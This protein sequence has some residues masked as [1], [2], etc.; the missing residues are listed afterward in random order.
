MSC[1]LHPS[2]LLQH[3]SFYPQ[4]QGHCQCTS[5]VVQTCAVTVCTGLLQALDILTL[6]DHTY[7][8]PSTH[9]A[10][11]P[12]PARLSS[13]GAQ[14]QYIAVSTACSIVMVVSLNQQSCLQ[15]SQ[16]LRS[17]NGS[18]FK[19][20]DYSPLV[21]QRLRQLFG[22]DNMDYLLSLTGDR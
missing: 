10:S 21:F 13:G 11:L 12:N 17:H 15:V 20:K 4:P 3:T 7:G 16:Y 14:D 8:K 19:W 1:S 6:T 5:C 18:S 22:I 9:I 2:T